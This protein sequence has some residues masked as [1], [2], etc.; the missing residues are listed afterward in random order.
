MFTFNYYN[1]ILVIEDDVSKAGSEP[2]MMWTPMPDLLTRL[3]Q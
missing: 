2:E 1:N 3:S